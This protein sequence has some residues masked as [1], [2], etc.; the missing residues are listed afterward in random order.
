[1]AVNVYTPGC[2]LLCHD[3]VIGSRRLSYILYLT[4]S[5][6]GGKGGW[7]R[8]WGGA[9]RLY[10]TEKIVEEG[11]NEKDGREALIPLPE[12]TVAIP[13]AWNQLA[14]FA[15]QPGESFH[16]VEEVYSAAARPLERD[17]GM[18]F[19]GKGKSKVTSDGKEAGD[20][21]RVRMAIS[22]WYHV[23]QEGESGYESVNEDDTAAKSSLAQLQNKTMEKH[24]L[25]AP[26]WQIYPCESS[27]AIAIDN[28]A[29][30]PATAESDANQD[31]E[32]TE[33]DL[34]FLIKHITPAY[35]T[36]DMVEKLADT[37]EE[38]SCLQLST[39]LR[40]DFADRLKLE[41]EAA[42]H[43][44]ENSMPG[45]S[46]LGGIARPPHKHRF[47]YRQPK[48]P[49][50]VN[51]QEISLSPSSSPYD[52]V[53]ESL[54][55]S[56]AFRK[57]LTLIT[58]GGLSLQRSNIIARRFRRG[59]DYTL[60]TPYEEDRPQLEVCLGITPS[61]GWILDDEEEDED[62]AREQDNN[63]NGNENENENDLTEK[64]SADRGD[65]SSNGKS[66]NKINHSSIGKKES[67]IP[68]GQSS[69]SSSIGSSSKNSSKNSN[70]TNTTNPKSKLTR[71][72]PSGGHDIYMSSGTTDDDNNNN[73]NNNNNKKK[74][75]QVDPAIYQTYPSTTSDDDGADGTDGTDSSSPILFSAP[76][77]YNTLNVVLRDKG[78][79]RFTKY[80]ALSGAPGDRWDVLGEWEVDDLDDDDDDD[81]DDDGDE[82]EDE[83]G[84][85]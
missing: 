58:G 38:E 84:N 33:S 44:G 41:I 70:H 43:E 63:G 47:L 18:D 82:D 79:L 76:P 81:D 60:A 56:A 52:S 7:K 65:S 57:F 6:Y 64:V 25:P 78:V 74:T 72:I 83:D 5:E 50:N 11:E 15:V 77:S 71:S 22:G 62:A 26:Q 51:Q 31:I 59:K 24:D 42:E 23:P 10:P 4:E 9:L 21:Q 29:E 16:D 53:L 17:E 37:F 32:L 45:E 67:D 19:I 55:P 68:N 13:P 20:E 54:F 3:D 85:R 8:E 48:L 12:H 46:K 61:K 69:S 49:E 73:N 66:K 34:D 35:L 30:N 28:G 80:L 2:H 1:M 14:F 36:P 27:A 40:P 75:N 39:F